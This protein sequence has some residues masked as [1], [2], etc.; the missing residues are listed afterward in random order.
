MSIIV[1]LEDG[2]NIMI[3][4]YEQIRRRRKKLGIL[5]K[6]MKH[7]IGMQQA[8]YQ[9]IETGGNIQIRTLERILKILKLQ[10]ILV[11]KE[12]VDMILPLL[13]EEADL[14]KVEYGKPLLDRFQV[15]EDD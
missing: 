7:L 11:P 9:K 3:K 2:Y 14:V 13:D 8:Q 15:R 4:I 12:K 10:L 6:D 1:S 5:Q